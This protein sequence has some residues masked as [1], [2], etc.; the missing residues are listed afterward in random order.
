LLNHKYRTKFKIGPRL[1]IAF[2]TIC[3]WV[4]VL[5]G[6]ALSGERALHSTLRRYDSH[7]MPSLRTIA[8]IS[9]G[10]SS[11]RRN[12]TQ[13]LVAATSAEM[14]ELESKIMQD[15]SQ[16]Q[17]NLDSYRNLVSGAEDSA[18][19]QKM[20]TQTHDYFQLQDRVL[21]LSR[22]PGQ[23]E[24]A[25]RLLLGDSRRAF[26]ALNDTALAW[27][28]L[29]EARADEAVR[30]GEVLYQHGMWTL[31]GLTCWLLLS[32]VLAS[33]RLTTSIIG[34]LDKA[35][36]LAKSVAGGDLTRRVEVAGSDEVNALLKSLNDMSS[37]LSGL[38]TDVR[39]SAEAVSATA[40]EIA[41]SNQELSQRTL[42]QA[43]TLEETAASMEEITSLGKN[44]SNNAG[45][46][47]RLGHQARELAE[48]GGSVVGQAVGAMGAINEG[49]A[50]ISNIISVIDDIAFQTNLLALNAA[51]E[52]ARAGEQGRGFAVVASEVRALAQ[53][54]AGAA[55][56]IKALI[57]DSADKVR[58]GTELVDRSGQALSQILHSVRDMTALIKEI[59]NSSHEQAEGVAR[60]NEAVLHLDGATQQ[61]A[62]LVEEGSAASRTLM[63]QA[64]TLFQRAAYFTVD[65]ASDRRTIVRRTQSPAALNDPPK[66]SREPTPLLKAG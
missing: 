20:R 45:N 23:H 58:A 62:A 28:R 24:L 34:P 1:G 32:V 11:M 3:L 17:A 39:T 43:A 19:Y 52:A 15:R 8:A 61:N 30:N 64:E 65:N 47:D 37:R 21:A 35:L 60:I 38:I 25:V 22:S 48:T 27:T 50:K 7:L 14:T 6:F 54:S 44:N 42:Q 2:G 16:V 13:D 55:K 59:A 46:A 53:R 4:L 57:T 66:K 33:M 56:E 10:V 31:I 9:Q 36:E 40:G 63:S 51:V 26:D 18:D 49:S 5:T 29:N 12:E 41:R